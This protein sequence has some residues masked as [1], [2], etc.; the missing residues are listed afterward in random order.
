MSYDLFRSLHRVNPFV[1]YFLRPIYRSFGGRYKPFTAEIMTGLASYAAHNTWIAISSNFDPEVTVKTM[2]VSSVIPG[3]HG[4]LGVLKERR[5]ER[6]KINYGRD[7][8]LFKGKKEGLGELITSEFQRREEEY[9][10]QSIFSR[11]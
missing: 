7:L 10:S 5:L 2:I 3:L 1:N 8:E 9:R 4:F 6:E 11:N